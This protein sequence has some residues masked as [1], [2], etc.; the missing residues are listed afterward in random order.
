MFAVEFVP[1]AARQAAEARDWWFEN[2]DKAPGAF[3][4][5][6]ADLVDRL[7]EAPHSVGIRVRQRPGV[8][9]ALLRRVRYHVYF[10]IEASSVTVIAVWHASRGSDPL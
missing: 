4:D 2:R 10:T 3:D 6:L 7:A 9:R 5:D 8:R 1:A